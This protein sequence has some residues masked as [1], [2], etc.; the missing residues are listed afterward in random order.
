MNV[1]L[2]P[3]LE[4]FVDAQASEGSYKDS[5]EVIRAALRLMTERERI[6]QA[7][8]DALREAVAKGDEALASSDFVTL[9]DEADI[10][11]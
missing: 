6:R 7:K 8:L 5:S 11:A 9:H 2:T 4:E 10:D 1:V 3:K